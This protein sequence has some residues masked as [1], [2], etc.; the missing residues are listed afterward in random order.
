[1]TFYNSCISSIYS[2]CIYICSSTFSAYSLI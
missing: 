2:T 1:M